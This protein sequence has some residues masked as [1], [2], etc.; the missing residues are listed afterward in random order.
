MGHPLRALHAKASLLVIVMAWP[1]NGAF[2]AVA[3]SPAEVLTSRGMVLSPMP[4]HVQRTGRLGRWC[5]TGGPALSLVFDM[6]EV[7]DEG[8]S[9]PLAP[10]PSPTHGPAVATAADTSH[11]MQTRG[12]LISTTRSRPLRF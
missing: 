11:V 10:L 4:L 12:P 5:Q 9:L 8:G 3:A 7:E 1:R 2:T 6:S